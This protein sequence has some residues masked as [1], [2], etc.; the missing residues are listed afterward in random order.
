M[1]KRKATSKKSQTN[2]T[3][4]SRGTSMEDTLYEKA[5]ARAKSL[6]MSWS[7]YVRRCLERDLRE[8]GD[9]V[10]MPRDRDS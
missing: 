2:R 1:P 5:L 7:E 4:V 9:V 6:G 8:G 10:I 3:F